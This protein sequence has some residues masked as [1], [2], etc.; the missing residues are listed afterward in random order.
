MI[1]KPDCQINP[2]K[3]NVE[4]MEL[5]VL[6]INSVQHKLDGNKAIEYCAKS[7]TAVVIT[8]V[9]CVKVIKTSASASETNGLQLYLE[10]DKAHVT[11][12]KLT[13][14]PNARVMFMD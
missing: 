14:Q 9:R 2:I 1:G 11:Q 5:Q 12:W 13:L 10:T 7:G 3:L 8:I 6:T 4:H